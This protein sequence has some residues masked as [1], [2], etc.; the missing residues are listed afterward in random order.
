MDTIVNDQGQGQDP[1]QDALNQIKAWKEAGETEKALEGC[2]EILEAAPENAEAKQLLSELESGATQPVAEETTTPDL[3]VTP[4]PE[5]GTTPETPVEAPAAPA[6]ET[7]VETPETPTE[8]P[9]EEEVTTPEAPAPAETPEAPETEAPAE[10]EVA[11]PEASAPEAPTSESETKTPEA[12]EESPLYT[13]STD[14]NNI[15]TPETSDAPEKEK[16]SHG[17]VL[18]LIIFVV[19]AAVIGIGV[20]A[21]LHFTGGS[22]EVIETPPAAEETIIEEEVAPEEEVVEEEVLEE[23]TEEADSIT[24][25]NDQR[26]L[27]LTVI[28]QALDEYY[29]ENHLYPNTADL[30]TELGELPYDPL[31]GQTDDLGQTFVYSYAVYDN[32]L[33][34]SQEYIL[35]G[36]FEEETGENTLWTTGAAASDHPDYRDSSLEN[37]VFITAAE[38][39]EEESTPKV[40]R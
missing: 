28:E 40:K 1:M 36:L 4:A 15:E 12:T 23:E 34:T 16:R 13:L 39:E 21:Y 25:R 22:D 3:Q 38:E 6:P 32:Y 19:V 27:D 8:A 31:D 7:P 18:N 33:G 24:S 11:A 5:E 29:T 17:I 10:E 9:A 35:A 2:K 37:I 30:L 26:F 14:E 20:Y